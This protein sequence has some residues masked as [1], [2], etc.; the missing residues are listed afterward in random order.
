MSKTYEIKSYCSVC[1][2]RKVCKYRDQV[3]AFE[4][5]YRTNST[6]LGPIVSL[7]VLCTE[8]LD[9]SRIID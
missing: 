9:D 8:R 6:T 1:G 7:Q 2:H 4:T 3:E 5:K